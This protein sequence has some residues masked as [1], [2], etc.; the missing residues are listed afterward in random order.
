MISIKL[1]ENFVENRLIIDK[2][3]NVIEN[4]PLPIILTNSVGNIVFV[5]KS[6]LELS[7]AASI[8]EVANEE[9]HNHID[10][11]DAGFLQ[12]TWAEAIETCEPQE[13][14]ITFINKVTKERQRKKLNISQVRGNGFVCYIT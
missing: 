4:A 9:W 11:K 8:S 1:A 14:N 12:N 10:P 7:G 3:R 6:Y 5:N 13:I 2:Y